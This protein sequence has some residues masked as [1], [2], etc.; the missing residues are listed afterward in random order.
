MCF[1]SPATPRDFWE[2]SNSFCSWAIYPVSQTLSLIPSW[3]WN[4][5][6]Y[7]WHKENSTIL[8][9]KSGHFVGQSCTVDWC[10][11]EE[12]LSRTLRFGS[13]KS[14]VV[15]GLSYRTSKSTE[16]TTVNRSSQLSLASEFTSKTRVIEAVVQAGRQEGYF[17]Q[18][19]HRYWARCGDRVSSAYCD[20]ESYNWVPQGQRE[21]R[22]NVDSQIVLMVFD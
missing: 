21:R 3:E 19:W 2:S 12:L 6:Y 11:V 20:E 5:K 14:Y 18:V 16:P 8:W 9:P 7:H 22:L 13:C 1:S 17:R 4:T 15:L 10:V